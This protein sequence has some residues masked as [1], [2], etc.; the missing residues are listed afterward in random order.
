MITI[1]EAPLVSNP[2]QTIGI[3]NAN[4]T[5]VKS[6]PKDTDGTKSKSIWV[7]RLFNFLKLLVFGLAVFVYDVYS[8][9]LLQSIIGYL[10]P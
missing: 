5:N 3:R 4:D 7:S 1:E 10:M 6:N 8:K 2:D 9:F